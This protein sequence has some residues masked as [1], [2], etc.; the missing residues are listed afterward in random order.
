MKSILPVILSSY[1]LFSL[2]CSSSDSNTGTTTSTQAVPKTAPS[3]NPADLNQATEP[4]A[5]VEEKSNTKTVDNKALAWVDNLN[6]RE[7][8]NIKSKVVARAKE[9]D[10][11]TLT[12]DKTDF[13]ETIELRGKS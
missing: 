5:A 10:P 1:L 3:I 9:N 8:P 12:G 4:E 6:I 2:A 13:T 7:Q 11:L